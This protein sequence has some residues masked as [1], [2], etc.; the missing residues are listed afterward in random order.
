MDY[1]I[2][3]FVNDYDAEEDYIDREDELA[4]A[5]TLNCAANGDVQS[6]R[7]LGEIYSSHG[8][9]V[10]NDLNKAIFWYGKASDAG[11]I[12][13]K[14]SLCR[15]LCE[16]EEPR[17]YARAFKLCIEAVQSDDSCSYA[18]SR[19]GYFYAHGLGV[20]KNEAKAEEFTAR[21]AL[22]GEREACYEYAQILKAK[23]AAEWTD[24][25][26]K[27]ADQSYGKAAW[28]M[29]DILLTRGDEG[30]DRRI[31]IYLTQAAYADI[32]EA[33]E[34]LAWFYFEGKHATKNLKLAENFFKLAASLGSEEGKLAMQ[35]YFN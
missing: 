4:F 14:T 6:M 18:L 1:T 32:V 9:G 13:S 30:Q 2:S 3:D 11:D 33:A 12:P 19:L 26:K 8:Y 22:Q 29:A 16:G 27:S 5:H 34:K 35:V 15:L 17:D 25:L 28:E 10:K 24:Y 31:I 23:G 7:L 20:E 21:A